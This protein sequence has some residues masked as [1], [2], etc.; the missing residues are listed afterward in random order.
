MEVHQRRNQLV[1]HKLTTA[2][3]RPALEGGSQ[4]ASLVY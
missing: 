4:E 1:K 3:K 2:G